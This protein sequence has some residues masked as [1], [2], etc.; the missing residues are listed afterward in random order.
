[1]NWSQPSMFDGVTF[2]VAD[3]RR[4]E[5]QLGRTYVKLRLG[6]W[7][8]LASLATYTGSSEAGVSAR[9]RDLRK[10][11]WGNHT[12]EA[13]RTDTG[14][15]IYKM[16]SELPLLDGKGWNPVT[17]KCPHCRGTGKVEQ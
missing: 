16:T 4:L 12:I 14:L 1:M 8:T 13:D 15:W 5:T 6:E 9:I 3:E 17:T 2:D 7:E 10:P 11:K